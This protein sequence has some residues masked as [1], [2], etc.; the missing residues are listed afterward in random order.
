MEL[1]YTERNGVMYPDLALPEQPPHR[2]VRQNAPRLS[3]KAP[4][5]ATKRLLSAAFILCFHTPNTERRFFARNYKFVFFN[6]L[7]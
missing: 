4:P 6:K 2:K 1:I 7:L 3:Q 5:R